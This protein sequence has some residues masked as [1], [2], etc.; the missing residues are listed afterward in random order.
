MKDALAMAA[1]AQASDPAIKAILDEVCR[2]TDMGFAAVA[3]VT[4][5]RWIA[6][7]VTDLIEFG[8]DPGDELKLKTTICD[9]IRQS[10]QMIVI[11]HVSMDQEWRTHPTPMLYGFESYVSLPLFLEDGLFF[12][13]LCAIDPRPRTLS[14]PALVATLESFASQV[15]AMLSADIP[16]RSNPK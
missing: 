9:D 4:D 5:D 6:C 1:V 11:D 7:Q 16:G 13:T 2:V 15:S 12:G 10:G 8:L 3:R 14:A